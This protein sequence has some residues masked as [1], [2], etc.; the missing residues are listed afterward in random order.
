MPDPR[1]SM[2]PAQPVSY[3]VCF[4]NRLSQDGDFSYMLCRSTVPSRM[5]C[6]QILYKCLFFEQQNVRTDWGKLRQKSQCYRNCLSKF[7]VSCEACAQSR[8]P[9]RAAW[10]LPVTCDLC[11]S[12]QKTF[13]LLSD[14]CS[15]LHRRVCWRSGC[16]GK[17]DCAVTFLS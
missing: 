3:Q 5:L 4:L 8:C 16:P 1:K 15:T 2:K 13:T 12:A 7:F 14:S 10:G 11:T 6:L 17:W 9:S